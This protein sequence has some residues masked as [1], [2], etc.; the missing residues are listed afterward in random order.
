[1]QPATPCT[2]SRIGARR[3][4]PDRDLHGWVASRLARA[5]DPQSTIWYS[6]TRSLYAD[7]IVSH[8]CLNLLRLAATSQYHRR[9]PTVTDE[10]YERAVADCM[11]EGGPGLMVLIEGHAAMEAVRNE[12]VNAVVTFPTNLR[13]ER[14]L[15]HYYP[16][17]ADV[18]AECLRAQVVDLYWLVEP[19]SELMVPAKVYRDRVD[20]A[21]AYAAVA[22]Y[23]LGSLR[24]AVPLADC[25]DHDRVSE[26]VLALDA[27]TEPGHVGD[28][29]AA[30]RWAEVL[31]IRGW[32]EWV[33][34]GD[35]GDD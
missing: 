8:Q 10:T 13:I 34:W 27:V 29:I 3:A 14:E 21:T 12:A 25:A 1:M 16:D 23:L 24:G 22:G 18:Q 4:A 26:L 6:P 35:A 20:M 28:Q 30:D 5:S 9:V 7:H 11:R 31:G 15:W 17:L 33:A 32:Y 2:Y 19:G